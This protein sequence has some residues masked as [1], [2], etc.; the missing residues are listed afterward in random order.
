VRWVSRLTTFAVVVIVTAGA[1][2][3][4]RSR[5]PT[6]EIGERFTTWTQFRDASRLQ[7]G[8]PVVI[9]GVRVGNITRLTI[10]GQ[11]ARI[12]MRLVDDIELPADS[13]ATRRADSLFGDSYVEIVLGEGSKLLR[14]GEPLVHV[15]EGGST[16][17]TLRTIARTMP[18]IDSAMNSVHDFMISGRKWV[19]G[20]M[21]DRLTGMDRWLSEGRIEGPLSSADRTMERFEDGTTRAADAVASAAPNVTKTLDRFDTGITS[22][23]KQMKDV[24][25][26]IVNAMHDAREG[27]D[28][29]DKPLAQMS[30]VLSAIDEGRGEDW[31]GTLGRLVNDP[32]LANTVE[33]VTADAAE[34]V[35]GF[36]RFKTWIGGRVEVSMLTGSMRVYASAEL[37]ARSDKFYLLEF[38]KSDLGGAVD[39]SLS[40]VAGT[41]DYTR[42]QEIK[43][44]LRFTAQVGKHFGFM[45]LRAGL[46]DSSVGVGADALFF[47][48]Q[49]RLSADV[50]GSFDHVPRLKVAG[51]FAVFR[52]LYILA[53]VDD[54]LNAPGKLPILAGNTPVP[55]EFTSLRYG[56]DYFVGAALHFDDADLATIL[57][58]YGALIAGFLLTQ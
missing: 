10:D 43:E 23:R 48:G 52:S 57:R 18:K 29:A 2:L 7:V 54:A 45:R 40:E 56:R 49:L 34:G 6:T 11:F 27:F 50:F 20:P 22:A 30:D 19:D 41:A 38:E 47:D 37:H 14:S 53:G 5:M 17:N 9:A 3:F 31:K 51:A 44:H 39:S 8:S 35:A 26:G 21:M 13:F 33:D 46:K 15:Q 55:V 36:N 4:I 24:K 12:D 58:V 42:S 1:A 32:E 16:D 25:E 28:R